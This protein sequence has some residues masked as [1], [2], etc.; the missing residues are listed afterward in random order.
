LLPF[1]T[2]RAADDCSFEKSH[3]Q[4]YSTAIKIVTS[5]GGNSCTIV[6]D[7]KQ[8]VAFANAKAMARYSVEAIPGTYSKMSI[9]L[10]PEPEL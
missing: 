2:A 10:F 4:G 5:N 3:S 1:S 8:S 6:L 7:V 9:N